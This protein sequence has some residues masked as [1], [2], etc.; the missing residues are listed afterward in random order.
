V[1]NESPQDVFFD[2]VTIQHHRGP[3]LEESHYYTYGLTQV[4][5]S[6]K[7][8]G[9]LETKYK[10]VGKEI[11]SEEF[12][13]GSG[14]E[15]FD[16]GARSYDPQI[17]RWFNVDPL[18]DRTRRFSSYNYA[19][20]NP[21]R[22]IDPDGMARKVD[23]G[24]E[25][26]ARRYAEDKRKSHGIDDN[27][28]NANISVSKVSGGFYGYQ[29][30]DT[31]VDP[32]TGDKKSVDYTEK[33]P[34]VALLR[35]KVISD[36][37]SDG[38]QIIQIHHGFSAAPAEIPGAPDYNVTVVD[39]KIHTR[40]GDK[41]ANPGTP[42]Y[43]SSDNL[44]DPNYANATWDASTNSG[45]ITLKDIPSVAEHEDKT[46]FETYFVLK[47]YDNSGK[48]LIVARVDWGFTSPSVLTAKPSGTSSPAISLTNS[49]SKAAANAVSAEYP[50]YQT[51]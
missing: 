49:F 24:A 16:F 42:Y 48:D 37:S 11:Q 27:N 38:L 23:L 30:T 50:G 4:G 1:S 18:A 35:I 2:N 12:S 33:N 28:D 3:L 29:H 51:Y 20:D 10:F 44:S 19:F 31:Q 41:E 47:N 6:S 43:N 46:N 5:I 17:G 13:D 39:N 15:I 40:N 34:L 9:K 7:S 45:E 22:F 32:T 8:T 21:I 25:E 26:Y 14:L 36:K